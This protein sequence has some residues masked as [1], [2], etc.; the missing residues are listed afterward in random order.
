MSVGGL[1]YK[2]ERA[3]KPFGEKKLTVISIHIPKIYL[4][5]IDDLVELGLY[6]SRAEAIRVAIRDMI[7]RD[8]DL[9]FK[10]LRIKD[11]MLLG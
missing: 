6:P 3:G 11:G 10:I 9:I 2:I 5:I 1:W 7:L 8:K 4:K